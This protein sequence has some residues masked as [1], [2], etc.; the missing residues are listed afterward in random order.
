MKLLIKKYIIKF[1]SFISKNFYFQNDL[2]IK[3]K[4][5]IYSAWITPKFKFVGNNTFFRYKQTL[6][7]QKYICFGDN[8][9]IDRSCIITAW[10]SYNCDKFNPCIKIGNNCRFGEFNHITAINNIIIGD[11]LLTGRWVTITDNSHGKSNINDLQLEPS[12]R[13]VYSKGAVIIGNNVWIG[14][15]ATILPGVKI[16]DGVIVGANTVVTKDIPN[17]CIVV[18]NPSKIIKI[19]I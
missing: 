2:I 19:N 11:G 6:Q 3:V 9:F 18:G 17:Y 8:C 1:V 5:L 16:G 10:N 4:D 12:K 7:G 14:D 13:N 15:K